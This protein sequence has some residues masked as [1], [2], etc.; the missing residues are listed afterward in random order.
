LLYFFSDNDV[1]T[2][3]N[4]LQYSPGDVI[5]EVVTQLGGNF[6]LLLLDKSIFTMDGLHTPTNHPV[7]VLHLHGT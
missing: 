6:E 2:V 5:D 7:M 1:A 4:S 3:D